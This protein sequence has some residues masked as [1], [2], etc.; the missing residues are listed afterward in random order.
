M[1]L[2][3]DQTAVLRRATAL[4]LRGVVSELR[5][6]SICVEDLPVGMGAQVKILP[7]RIGESGP[8]YGEV[9]GFDGM[10]TLV[11]PLGETAGI[12]P[13]DAV[14]AEHATQQVRVG[15]STLGRV[16]DGLGNPIDG[17]GPMRDTRPQSLNP[18][19]ID[20]M[21]RPPVDEPLATGVRAV[22]TLMP[23]GKGQRLGVF[24]APGVGKSTL[25][26]TIAKHTSA[27]VSVI[28][29]I[30]ERGREVR[31]FIEKTLGDEGRARSVVVVATSDEPALVRLRAAETACA[32]A[33]YFRD[34][35]LD[36]L[37]IMDSVTRYAH[38]Q[39]QVGLAIGEPPATRGY[40]PSV[41]AKLPRLLERSGRTDTGSVTGFFSVLVEGDDMDEPI[42][43]TCRGILDGHV[44]LSRKL[45]EKGH[46]PAIDVLGSVSRCAVDVSDAEHQLVGQ[47]VL[48]LLSAYA[49]V[50]DLVNIG[51]YAPG[52]NP[53]AD[54]AITIKPAIERLLR[55]GRGEVKGQ[56]Q[57]AVARAQLMALKA[58][59]QE[60]Q[61]QLQ[62]TARPGA[63]GQRPR[64]S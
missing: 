1:T 9:V 8:V 35:G 53:D 32:V 46:Y 48:R 6:L 61:K 26:G 18:Q 27:D 51:A 15:M 20:P 56:A 21:R 29:L 63:G 57:F 23:V 22:D 36:V 45:A 58:A 2:F 44:L 11:M 3:A 37:F 24:A 50:E 12:G 40:P 31:D 43:D 13:G 34:Q 7:R 42:A 10:R 39:R 16:L 4:E 55:Q 28:A 59:M 30:G 25:L 52:A 17:L 47:Q 19:T 62:S 60:G 14:I 41:F 54:L 64:S 49:E 33:E 5:G 38:A